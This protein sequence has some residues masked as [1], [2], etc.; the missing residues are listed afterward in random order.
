MQIVWT[1][2]SI[3][4]LDAI[5]AYISELNPDTATRIVNDIYSK[6]E[7]LLSANPF[8]G[9][10]GEIQGTRELIIPRTPYIIAYRVNENQVEILFVQH[11]AREWPA[12][13]R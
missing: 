4:E 12:T 3:R 13:L 8:V 10:I 6:T 2:R 1:K 11:G 5:G 7:K 9:R